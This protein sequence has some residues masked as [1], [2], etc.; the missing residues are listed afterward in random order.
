M[1]I[2]CPHCRHPVSW[3]RR[4][5][6]ALVIYEWDCDNCNSRLRFDGNRR[7]LIGWVVVLVSVSAIIWF[8]NGGTNL[9]L[10]FLATLVTLVYVS[11]VFFE[12]VVVIDGR[13]VR[14]PKCGY[15]L[16]GQAEPRCP[17]CNTSFDS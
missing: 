1:A 13:G 12:R 7:Y 15:D 16:R 2:K 8:V 5:F 4:L 10:G 6:L 14:C 17:E 9:S 11:T 3:F